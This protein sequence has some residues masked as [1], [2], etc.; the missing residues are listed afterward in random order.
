MCENYKFKSVQ[1]LRVLTH[2]GRK[3]RIW[4]WQVG[5][6]VVLDIGGDTIQRNKYVG[7]R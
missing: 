7:I 5:A 2:N 1:K 6:I 3:T 4:N